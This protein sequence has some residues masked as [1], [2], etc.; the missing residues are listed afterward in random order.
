MIRP[1]LNNWVGIGSILQKVFFFAGLI[2]LTSCQYQFGRGELTQ[3]YSTIS[4]PYVDGDLK[5]ELTTHVIRKLSSSGVFRY[6]DCN[7][8]LILKI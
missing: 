1:F 2:L 8:E 6:V 3:Q 7:G 4:V 5:G